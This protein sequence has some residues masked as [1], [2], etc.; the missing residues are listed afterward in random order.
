MTQK[1]KKFSVWIM[2]T[3]RTGHTWRKMDEFDTR[4]QADDYV[5]YHKEIVAKPP[6]GYY[7]YK[8]EPINR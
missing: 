2:R 5:S 7:R 4:L 3:R 1:S 6:K 8:V